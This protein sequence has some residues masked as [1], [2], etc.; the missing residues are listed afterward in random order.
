MNANDMIRRDRNGIIERSQNHRKQ[1]RVATRIETK[2]LANIIDISIS[3]ITLSV[4]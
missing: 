2:T 3:I 1:K 4:F